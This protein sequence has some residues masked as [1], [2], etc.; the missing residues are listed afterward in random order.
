MVAYI[1]TQKSGSI[2]RKSIHCIR[3]VPLTAELWL[4]KDT[5]DENGF[6]LLKELV[7]KAK[8]PLG[9]A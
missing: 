9:G 6:P 5:K 7:K 4:Q 2:C 3:P 1:I 8:T